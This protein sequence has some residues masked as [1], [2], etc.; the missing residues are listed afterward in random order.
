MSGDDSKRLGSHWLT[1][2]LG[3]ALLAGGLASVLLSIEARGE[4]EPPGIAPAALVT[5]AQAEVRTSVVAEVMSATPRAGRTSFALGAGLLG[6]GAGLLVC[7]AFCARPG[8]GPRFAAGILAL[9]T[10]AASSL[11]VLRVREAPVA[12]QAKS[13]ATEWAPFVIVPALLA[14]G[15]RR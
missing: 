14:L 15:A 2:L 13:A 11:L 4:A 10:L 12:A 6:V 9:V 8:R 1:N 7:T 5:G 3:L